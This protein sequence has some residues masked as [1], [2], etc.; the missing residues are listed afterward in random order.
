[1]MRRHPAVVLLIASLVATTGCGGR[2]NN[3]WVTG[4]LLKGGEKYVPPKDQH[5]NVT[6]VGLE[7]RDESGKPLPS[8]EPYWAELD[9]AN[10]TFSVPGPDGQG[11]PPGKYRVAVTQKLERVA[12]D[13]APKSKDTKKRIDRDADLL[14]DKFGV[15]TSPIV[16]EFTK[17]T[18][19]EI[20]LDK[21]SGS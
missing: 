4:K 13:K 11:I 17:S 18:D 20:D 12:F 21:P 10:G 6:F 1:M 19:L 5:V 15:T 8:G 7:V 2:G 14:K 3:V 9:Q 16:R